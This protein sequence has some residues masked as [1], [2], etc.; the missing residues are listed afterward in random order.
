MNRTL[1]RVARTIAQ[2]IAAG[3][4][5]ALVVAITEGLSPNVKAVVLA[6][7]TVLVAL[8][9]NLLEGSGTIP[10]VFEPPAARAE[11]PA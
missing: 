3:G 1:S 2:L 10:T 5:T 11:P 6:G 7:A 8:C 9:Q 4:L